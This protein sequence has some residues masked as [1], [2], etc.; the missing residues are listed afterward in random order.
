MFLAF[1]EDLLLCNLSKKAEFIDFDLFFQY[2][3]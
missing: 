3:F 1:S 2:T